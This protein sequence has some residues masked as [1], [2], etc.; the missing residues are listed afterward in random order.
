LINHGV[1]LDLFNGIREQ[2]H[3]FF[4]LK[5]EEKLKYA[6]KIGVRGYMRSLK[7]NDESKG[8]LFE[9]LNIYP[10][11]GHY[12][13]GRAED[14]QETGQQITDPNGSDAL[15][16][17]VIWPSEA[18]RELCEAYLQHINRLAHSVLSAIATSLGDPDLFSNW[19]QDPYCSMRIASYPD[20]SAQGL[21]GDE[22]I[23]FKPHTDFG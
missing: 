10:P 13:N 22:C 18:L 11:V 19:F 7:D 8:L 20:L 16:D 1:P 2:G 12:I 23:N 4:D 15:G 3:A 9:G 5:L 14:G 21:T 17:Q 6:L